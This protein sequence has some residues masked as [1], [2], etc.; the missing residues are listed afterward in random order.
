MRED[1]VTKDTYTEGSS[2]DA[3]KRKQI[4]GKKQ[5]YLHVVR[6]EMKKK[7]VAIIMIFLLVA[8]SSVSAKEESHF[9][10][11][12]YEKAFKPLSEEVGAKTGEG[13]VLTIR[14]SRIIGQQT[15]S[16]FSIAMLEFGD[17]ETKEVVLGIGEYRR[18]MQSEL[19][20][21]SDELKKQNF[22]SYKA[23]LSI[24]QTV[25]EDVDT[26]LADVLGQ[27]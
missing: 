19:T 25:A 20:T 16:A 18:Q 15:K 21:T 13:L 17:A 5:T 2:T 3:T 1:T 4:R 10:K 23:Q 7:L 26:L 24:E 27:E 14:T 22:E 11:D 8:S 12:W 6:C 9:L